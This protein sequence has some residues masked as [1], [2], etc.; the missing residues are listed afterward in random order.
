M[1]NIFDEKYQLFCQIVF[2]KIH[3]KSFESLKRSK[4]LLFIETYRKDRYISGEDVHAPVLKYYGIP[5]LSMRN[6]LYQCR[7]CLPYPLPMR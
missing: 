1:V 5:Q 6:I 4:A 3:R 2:L 7:Y